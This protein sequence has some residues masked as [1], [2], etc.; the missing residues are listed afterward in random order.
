MP[1]PSVEAS[2]RILWHDGWGPFEPFAEVRLVDAVEV[3]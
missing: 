1:F 3:E 2:V